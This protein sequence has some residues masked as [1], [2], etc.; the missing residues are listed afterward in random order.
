MRHANT[1]QMDMFL[2]EVS[3]DWK[4]CFVIILEDGAGWHKSGRL[5]VPE[6]IKL[7]YQPSRIPKLNPVERLWKE[8]R[9]NYLPNMAFGSLDAVKKALIDGLRQPCD[10]PERTRSMTNFEYLSVTL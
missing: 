7:V 6:S 1:E 2:E 3:K 5:K 4:D 10:N 8:L 9:E